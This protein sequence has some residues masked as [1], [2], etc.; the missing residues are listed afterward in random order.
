V[1]IE[2][3]EPSNLI[4]LPDFFDTHSLSSIKFKDVRDNI[5]IDSFSRADANSV[6]LLSGQLRVIVCHNSLIDKLNAFCPSYAMYIVQEIVDPKNPD[7]KCSC[8]FITSLN[9]NRDKLGPSSWI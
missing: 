7:L 8:K 3:F 4:L 9:N 1:L 6:R 5:V 2:A